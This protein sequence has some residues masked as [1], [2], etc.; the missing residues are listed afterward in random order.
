MPYKANQIAE[1]RKDTPSLKNYSDSKVK[2][3]IKY[4]MLL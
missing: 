1:A 4:S 3:F 2:S